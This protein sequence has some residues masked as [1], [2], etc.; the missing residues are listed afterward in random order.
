MDDEPSRSTTY[1]LWDSFAAGHPVTRR[2]YF[3]SSLKNMKAE[4]C[5]SAQGGYTMR[6]QGAINL[7]RQ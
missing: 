4:E 2:L 7:P 6:T 5:I 3:V 1:Y